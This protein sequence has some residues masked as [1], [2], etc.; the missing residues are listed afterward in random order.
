MSAPGSRSSIPRCY[1]VVPCHLGTRAE[2]VLPRVGQAEQ[3][4][5]NRRNDELIRG[6][7][8][9]F[10]G[11]LG[12]RGG[13]RSIIRGAGA[14]AGRRGR[15]SEAGKRVDAARNRVEEK[16]EALGDLQAELTDELATITEDWDAKEAA[17]TTLEVPLERSDITIVDLT[18]VWVPV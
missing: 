13:V 3:S 16:T 18:L 8:D 2:P 12:G 10:G 5:D 15:T 7:A 6:A 14:A 17:T 4:A 9:V 11:L 1:A